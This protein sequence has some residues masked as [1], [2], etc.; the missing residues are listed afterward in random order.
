VE[1]PVREESFEHSNHLYV[2]WYDKGGRCIA[3][4]AFHDFAD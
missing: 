1:R 4:D 3:Y 2:A